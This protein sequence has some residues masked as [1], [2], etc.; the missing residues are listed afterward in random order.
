[1]TPSSRQEKGYHRL[2]AWQEAHRLALAVYKATDKFP[3]AELFG[4]TSQMRR[5]VVSTAANIA[6]GQA[7]RTKNE[8]VH[9]LYIA[10]GSLVELEYYLELGR[11]LGLLSAET[12]DELESI[13]FRVGYVL[14]GLIASPPARD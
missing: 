1:M 6:E 13:R 10:N 9:F 14:H 2:V 11:D 8:F 5:A 3:R 7:R 4:L 12:Y